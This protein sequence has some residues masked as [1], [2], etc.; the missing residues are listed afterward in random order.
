MTYAGATR[1]VSP[2]PPAGACGFDEFLADNP[3]L[4]DKRLLSRHYSNAALSSEPA[5]VVPFQWRDAAI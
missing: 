5:D 4:L 1:S 2:I 3:L